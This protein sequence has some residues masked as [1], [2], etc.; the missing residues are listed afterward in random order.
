MGADASVRDSIGMPATPHLEGTM[1]IEAV[2]RSIE[3]LQH[4]VRIGPHALVADEPPENGGEDAGPSPF[5]LLAA[6]LGT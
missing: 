5:G 1:R 6:A 2:I 3:R 4:E